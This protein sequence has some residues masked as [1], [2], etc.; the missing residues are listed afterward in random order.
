MAWNINNT[1]HKALWATI[2][3]DHRPE[4]KRVKFKDGGN[5]QLG[6]IIRAATGASAQDVKQKA[7]AYANKIDDFLTSFFGAKYENES[8]QQK[9]LTALED[10]LINT[11]NTLSDVGDIVDEHYL[12]IGEVE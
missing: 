9:A 6:F 1:A 10:A 11:E 12:M 2:R 5:W 4:S 3:F 8:N 7:E